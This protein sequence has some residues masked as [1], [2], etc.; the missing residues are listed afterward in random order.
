MSIKVLWD[1]MLCQVIVANIFKDRSASP[2]GSP[3]QEER[4]TNEDL[5]VLYMRRHW[6]R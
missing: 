4:A 2:P 6:C 3:V 1:V 5:G